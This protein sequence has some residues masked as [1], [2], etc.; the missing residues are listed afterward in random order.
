MKLTDSGVSIDNELGGVS[1]RSQ[2]DAAAV[3]IFIRHNSIHNQKQNKTR[4]RGFETAK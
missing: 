2:N 4:G 3:R 1:R